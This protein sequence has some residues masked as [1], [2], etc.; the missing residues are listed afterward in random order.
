VPVFDFEALLHPG[1]AFESPVDVL[2]AQTLT[3]SEKRAILA[4]GAPDASGIA[5]YWGLRSPPGLKM[6]VT[7]DD[8]LESLQSLDDCGPPE[9]PGGKSKRLRSVSRVLAA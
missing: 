9:P 4:S 7:I 8:V 2:K 1:T 6:P 3:P 5:S